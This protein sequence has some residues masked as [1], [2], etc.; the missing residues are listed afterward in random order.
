MFATILG[1]LNGLSI[2]SW[3]AIAAIGSVSIAI[4]LVVVNAIKGRQSFSFLIEQKNV[5]IH[6]DDGEIDEK[7]VSVKI[8]NKSTNGLS[9]ERLLFNFLKKGKNK[10]VFS[11]EGYGRSEQIQYPVEIIPKGSYD[12]LC[13]G[14]FVKRSVE[15][16]NLMSNDMTVE[17]RLSNG[18]SHTKKIKGGF[19][20]LVAKS[21]SG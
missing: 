4:A 7:I 10:K 16:F 1:Q 2:E 15:D 3:G 19:A 11:L 6:F 21:L 13:H 5:K 18:E 8:R 14:R 17:V 12:F 9:V 20:F